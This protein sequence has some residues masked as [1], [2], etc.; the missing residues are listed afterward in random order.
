MRFK[1]RGTIAVEDIIEV[2]QRVM[3][4]VQDAGVTHISGVNV[5][6]SPSDR[7]GKRR[8]FV[9]DGLEVDEVSIETWDLTEPEPVAEMST[10]YADEPT[11]PSAQN[12]R[13]FGGPGRGRAYRRG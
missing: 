10:V 11:N 8:R 12:A 4:Q 6:L 3:A 2:A 5:Y 9:R 13:R 1:T 7:D